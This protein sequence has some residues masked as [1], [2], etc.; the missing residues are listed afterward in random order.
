[1]IF[2]FRDL[3]AW[4]AGAL[5]IWP[6]CLMIDDDDYDDDDVYWCDFSTVIW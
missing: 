2:G 1:M 4:E 6:P 3:P 5:L